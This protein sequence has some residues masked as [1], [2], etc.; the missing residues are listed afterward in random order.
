MG[1]IHKPSLLRIQPL[2][3]TTCPHPVNWYP[4]GKDKRLFRSFKD[5]KANQKASPDDIQVI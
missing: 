2:S 1:R 5:G 4:W 3:F